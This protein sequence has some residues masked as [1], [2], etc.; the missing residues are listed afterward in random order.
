MTR[1][2]CQQ[3]EGD[4]ERERSRGS[5]PRLVK[6]GLLEDFAAPLLQLGHVQYG[7]LTHIKPCAPPAAAAQVLL[8]AAQHEAAAKPQEHAAAQQQDVK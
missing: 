5:G 2:R 8:R 4:R 6:A 3:S 7:P 1:G